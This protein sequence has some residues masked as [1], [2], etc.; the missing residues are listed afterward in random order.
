M[1][2]RELTAIFLLIMF[3]CFVSCSKETA[4]TETTEHTGTENT[5]VWVFGKDFVPATS[6]RSREFIGVIGEGST[7]AI[8]EKPDEFTGKSWRSYFGSLYPV[9]NITLDDLQSCS[10]QRY[11]TILHFSQEGNYAKMDPSDGNIY[12]RYTLTDN[13]INFSPPI[14]VVRFARE[15]IVAELHYSNEIHFEG[16]PVL[17]SDDETVVFSANGSQRPNNGDIVRM[18]QYYCVK[19]WESGKI[20]TNGLLYG[21]PDTSSINI[22]EDD[23]YGGKATGATAVKLAEITIDDVVWYY[24]LVDFTSG[25]PTDG[26]GPFFYGWLS[27][28][29]FE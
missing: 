19:T 27:A 17:R 11:D 8:P 26:G 5:A 3:F 14:K 15:F 4:K 6:E 10:W 25:E 2:K 7:P 28:E 21:L 12:G 20:N 23:Y 13:T 16:A 24:T 22:F 18:Y 1:K 9:E 29:F